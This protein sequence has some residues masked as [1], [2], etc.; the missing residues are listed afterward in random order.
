MSELEAGSLAVPSES[1]HIQSTET[2]T[3]PTETNIPSSESV[4]SHIE[5]E[6]HEESDESKV[7][8]NGENAKRRIDNRNRKSQREIDEL[9]GQVQYLAQLHAQNQAQA[10]NPYAQPTPYQQQ[11]QAQ[12]QQAQAP[13]VDPFTGEYLTP[14]TPR[15]ETVLF[16][17]Q[18]QQLAVM[19]EQEQ[20]QREDAAMLQARQDKFF[21]AL[22]AASDK[23]ADFDEVV[24]NK[25]LPL[26]ESMLNVAMATRN[27]AD[28]LYFLGKNPKE[29]Q[30]ISKLH[31][32]LQ[33]E[34]VANHALEL[35]ARRNVSNAPPPT[36]SIGET[37]GGK[38]INSFNKLAQ[39][40][41]DLRNYYRSKEGRPKK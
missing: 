27:G 33:Q 14:G 9:K 6:A 13:I 23:Y 29:V 4:E 12:V 8:N 32:L 21:D 25:D 7:T 41:R 10:Q 38:S 5:H 1:V 19:K 17:Q 26:T 39:N 22:D 15:Y 35:A 11:Y 3:Y 2:L 24:R 34:V 16:R 36:A 20:K 40:P 37:S 30:R 31:P 18:E 28:L